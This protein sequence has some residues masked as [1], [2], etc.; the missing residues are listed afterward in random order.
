[1]YI[2]GHHGYNAY[3]YEVVKVSLLL[4]VKEPT[5]MDFPMSGYE[6]FPC[7]PDS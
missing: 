2:S 3:H 4:A 7:I 1:M 5:G 6:A